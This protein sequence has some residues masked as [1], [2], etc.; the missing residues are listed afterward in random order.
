MTDHLEAKYNS[1][2]AVFAKLC[3]EGLIRREGRGNYVPNTPGI[4]LH[5]M[6]KIEGLENDRT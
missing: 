4:L 6:D 1:V 5:I 2:K 3:K